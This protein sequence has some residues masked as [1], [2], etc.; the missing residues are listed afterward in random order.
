MVIDKKIKAK[1]LAWN[2][3]EPIFKQFERKCSTLSRI[4]NLV[5]DPNTYQLQYEL[6]LSSMDTYIDLQ[7]EAYKAIHE[8]YPQIEFGMS[9]RLKS[10]FSHYEKVIRK[11]IDLFEKDEI[12]PVEIL[13]DYAMKIFLFSKDYVVDKVAID[14]EGIYIDSEADEFRICDKDAFEFKVKDPNFETKL[15]TINAVVENGQTNVT[16]ENGIPYIYTSLNNETLS[17]PLHHAVKYKRSNKDDLV[18]YCY[19]I[20]R[21]V[22]NFFNKNGFATK[23]RKDYIARPKESGYSS[24]QCSFYSDELSLGLECQIRTQ[25][26]ELFNNLER[27]YGYKPDEKKI[28]T[29]SLKKVP[30]FVL[31]T[32]F[33]D[34]PH[35][36]ALSDAECFKYVY[37]ITLQEYRRQMKPTIEFKNKR[38]KNRRRT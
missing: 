11:F 10:H 15:K 4:S 25:D 12:K 28:S 5:I 30:R 23:K 20:Q 27:E 16:I 29:N 8:K 2:D 21:E 24:N 31:T 6:H 32:N 17:F 36:F 34:G 7:N 35:S 3:K 33:A 1:L 22:E 37:G 14:S 9:G 19:D 13:D 26:M 18:P 38:S